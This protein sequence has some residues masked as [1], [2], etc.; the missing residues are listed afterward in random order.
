MKQPFDVFAK[1]FTGLPDP[2][3]NNFAQIFP[4]Q[5]LIGTIYSTF[6]KGQKNG[7]M[8]KPFY[9]SQ[10]VSKKAQF[11]GFGLSKRPNGNPGFSLI[12]VVDRK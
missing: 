10:T 8:A 4:K 6:K 1:L 5:S 2:K 11:G 3:K 9:F 12:V 7:Q